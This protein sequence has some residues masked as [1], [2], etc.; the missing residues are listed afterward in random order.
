MGDFGISW[1]EI[2]ERYE[3]CQR[4]HTFMQLDSRRERSYR[5]YEGDQWF[6]TPHADKNLPKYNFIKPTVDYRFNSV[7]QNRLSVVYSCQQRKALCDA[8]TDEVRKAWDML[9]LD[10]LI[11]S[12]VKD[13]CIAGDS[14]IF[15][16]D[17]GSAQRISSVDI[18]FADE[19]DDRLQLQP[20][21][22]IRE[23]R[24]IDDIRH[25]ARLNGVS[26]EELR[27]LV[28]DNAVLGLD[29]EL[30]KCTS[31]LYLT[32]LDGVVNVCRCVRGLV[33][34][35]MVAIK[36]APGKALVRYPIVGMVWNR[37]HGFCRGVGE[38]YP[39]IA[40]QIKCN[41]SLVHRLATVKL[42]AY[43]KPVYNIN[44]VTN[45]DA[46]FEAGASI[47]VDGVVGSVRD[48]VSYLE[49]SSMSSDAHLM[50]SELITKSRE[51]AGAGDAALGQIDP[52]Q[53]SGAAIVAARDQSALPMNE[54]VSA[55]KQMV[56]DIGRTF[57]ALW[58]VYR[59]FMDTSLQME[60]SSAVSVDISSDDAFSRLAKEQALEGMLSAGHITF[61]EYVES[62]PNGCTAPKAELERLLASRRAKAES[63]ETV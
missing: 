7:M 63:A 23:R 3:S 13:S 24:H 1:S 44:A 49:P 26:D 17:D 46:L 22:I 32:K 40:N 29:S 25:E 37:R 58:A 20:W 57:L 34:S 59:D 27:A 21:I 55:L 15:F 38:V 9:S 52:T 28:P 39:L 41:E 43:G 16:G 61:E 47:Q 18:F 50:A 48:Y 8:L 5:Y 62:L 42:S 53:S 14:Y 36:S 51:L 60:L 54:Y 4:S 45:P 12:V 10:S 19:A 31:L 33:Y 35:P 11:G 56:E 2:W 30:E 6:E